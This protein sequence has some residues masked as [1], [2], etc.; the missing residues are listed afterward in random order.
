MATAPR[1]AV[2]VFKEQARATPRRLKAAFRDIAVSPS[3]LLPQPLPPPSPS[4]G[5]Q[6][7]LASKVNLT[8]QRVPGSR[9]G[10]ASG[11]GE[12]DSGPRAGGRDGTRCSVVLSP[13][14]IALVPASG[15]LGP[16]ASPSPRA[17]QPQPSWLSNPA[18]LRLE[19][20]RCHRE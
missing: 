2:R 7:S 16:P 14:N 5:H 13:A 8:P 10:P 17:G 6:V 19:C 12:R 4:S 18:A 15:P 3:P 11:G 9:A 20:R 1:R